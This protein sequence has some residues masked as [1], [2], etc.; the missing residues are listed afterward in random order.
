MTKKEE[1][2]DQ[3]LSLTK[4]YYEEVHGKGKEFVAGE[5]FVNYGGRYFDAGFWKPMDTLRDNVELNEMW[6][7]GKAPWKVW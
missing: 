1:L 5:S 3:I 4:A 6:D 7:T 2:K